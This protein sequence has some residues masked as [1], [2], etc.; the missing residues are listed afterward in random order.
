L[1]ADT[2]SLS[3]CCYEPAQHRSV[4]SCK[5]HPLMTKCIKWLGGV[6]FCLQMTQCCMLG[7]YAQA[8]NVCGLNNCA[9]CLSTRVGNGVCCCKTR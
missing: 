1:Q 8:I 9:Y 5:F 2:T 6:P 3:V 7:K 4:L